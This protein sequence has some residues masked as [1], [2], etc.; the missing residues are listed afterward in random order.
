MRIPPLPSL[1]AFA[2]L[3]PSLGVCQ[4]YTNCHTPESAGN[5]I[6]VDEVMI[7]GVICTVVKA[8]PAAQQLAANQ[9]GLPPPASRKDSSASSPETTAIITNARVVD[10]TKLGLDDDI[11][12]AKIRN[13]NCQFQLA[14]DTDLVALK[15]AGV[16]PKVIAAMLDANAAAS[17]K[18][19]ANSVEP[20]APGI[21]RTKSE[22]SSN[23]PLSEPGM[24][25]AASGGFAKILGQIVDTKRTGSMLV[26]DLTLHI[27]TSKENVQILGAHAQTVLGSNP[28]FYFVPAKQEADTGVN[29]GDLILIRLEEKSDR[30]QFEIGA[31]GAWRAS[32]GVALSHEIQLSRSEARSGV[33]KI[34]PASGL[35]RGEYG[36]YLSR[37]EGMAPYIYDFSVQ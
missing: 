11:L 15:K 5:F 31:K 27:K 4:Q 25:V 33:Y 1:F 14:A 2:A 34:Q 10:L 35:T 16:S 21:G 24:Y 26:S 28:E 18:S 20:V 19:A 17:A 8:Q 22:G 29:A 7:N 23:D 6:A 9:P 37:G 32:S 30:R 13:G 3:T 12:I 36:L